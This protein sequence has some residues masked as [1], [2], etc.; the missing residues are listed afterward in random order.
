MGVCAVAACVVLG[1]HAQ[2][3]PPS[4][5]EQGE[6]QE[7]QARE[8]EAAQRERL[9]RM[10]DA[11]S[12]APAP[13]ATPWPSSESPCFEIR[14]VHLV[15]DAADT[16]SRSLGGVLAGPDSA[17]GR[18][19]GVQGVNV[20]AERAQQALIEQGYVTSRI[21][22]AP[23]DLSGGR[24]ELTVVPGRIRAIR[25]AAGT[26]DRA[27]LVN[28]IPARP[29]DLLNLRDIEQG[30]ENLKRVPTAQADIQIEPGDE[31]GQSDLVVSWQQA[32][33]F[34]LLTSLDDGGSAA[35]GKYQGSVTVSYDHAF[36][37]NDLL[38]L[39]INHDLGGGDTGRRGTRGHTA[40]YSI[41]WGDWLLAL[42][43]SQNRYHQS[44]AGL[45]QDYL[46][47]GDSQN[48]EARLSRLLYRDASRKT[49]LGLKAWMKRS[50]NFIDDT[51]VRP[52]R[53][54]TGGWELGLAHK[55]SLGTSTL[56][57]SLAH[58]RGTAAFGAQRAPEES[59]GEGTS[60]LRLST[61]EVNLQ[62]PF[63]LGSHKLRYLG[64]YRAQW[65]GTPLTPQDRFAIGGRYTVRGFDGESSLS[66][67]RGW[68]VRNDWVASL[69]EGG[70]EP[71]L[72]LDYGQVRGPSSAN[73]VG[74]HLAGVVLGLRG[75]VKRLGFDVF[76]GKPVSRPTY[77]RSASVTAGFS[78]NASF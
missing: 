55:E 61:A 58:R 23:Q 40:H 6:Q 57:L 49:T 35:T 64:T 8:R 45:S 10:P 78:L 66:A 48:A 5:R 52:Q 17:I 12:S 9:E 72:G 30:L 47:S 33:P 43:A 14:H 27:T 4:V 44:V 42:T 54:A 67:D 75:N 2:S 24:L 28:A 26:T 70:L 15:G 62:V 59:F 56:E 53:R 63:Q 71:Y 37:L 38:Y 29:G 20:A 51:E 11:T 39:T 25:W 34:R 32:F 68:L 50:A 46:Y 3:T 60:R 19:L 74:K 36:T 13:V 18:C 69:G 21:L 41:P 77:F 76:V 65:N 16:L 7:R 73:L 22:L 31:P 1:A